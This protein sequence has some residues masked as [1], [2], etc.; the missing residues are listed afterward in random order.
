[1]YVE[2]Y[3]GQSLLIFNRMSEFMAG[4]YHCMA[5]YANSEFLISKVVI[6]TFGEW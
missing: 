3:A 5:S 6:G 1:M 2:T 4:T